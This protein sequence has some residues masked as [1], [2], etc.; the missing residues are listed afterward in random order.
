MAAMAYLPKGMIGAPYLKNNAL[1]EKVIVL[2]IDGMD[3][4]LLRRFVAEGHLPGFKKLIDQGYFSRLATTMPPQSPVAWSSFISGANPGKHGIFDFIHRDPAAFLPYLSTSKTTGSGDTLEIGK[5]NI[6]IESAKVEL[7]R[8]GPVFW[9]VLED[10]GVSS[11]L[12]KIPAAFPIVEKGD[13]TKIMSGMGTP[14]VLGSYGTFN[15]FSEVDVPGSKG[16]T[17]GK[18]F[19]LNPV[20]HVAKATLPGPRNDLVDDVK[21]SEIDFTINRDPWEKT[22]RIDLQDQQLVLKQ[23]EWSEWVPLK[24]E[25]LPMFVSVSGMVRIYVQEVHPYLKIYMTP[26]NVDPANPAIPICNPD[27]YSKD[28]TEAI[29][30]FYTQGF[31]EDT[32]ALSN[33]IFTDEEFWEQAKL[34]L[35]E[36]LKSFHHQFDSFKDGF[37]FY[38]FSSIDQC[39]HML[40]RN[41][42]PGHPLYDPKAS[43][44]VKKA[45]LYLYKKMDKVLQTTLAK[46]DNKTRLMIMS[47]HGFA[48]F[49]REFNVSTWLVE[50]GFT[51]MRNPDKM[52]QCKLY[53]MVDWANTKAYAMGLNGIY[54]NLQDR[55]KQGSLSP[56]EAAEVKRQIITKLNQVKDPVTGKRVIAQ[57][58]DSAEIYDGPFL[59][60]A[61][62]I[63]IGYAEGYRISDE[64]ALGTFPGEV[65]RDRTNKW[66]ADHCMDSAIVPGI[67]LSNTEV[68]K[69]DPALWDLAPTILDAFGLEVPKEMDGKPIFKA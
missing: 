61:P 26:V 2:G 52:E 31:P 53:N 69:K 40:W 24:F 63:I 49:E 37:F 68:K 43:E 64:A 50:N 27:S 46:V 48:T 19:K 11:S 45:L 62:D 32:K 33:G 20:D 29:G 5:Y 3:P 1:A 13:T 10:H 44:K 4:N 65:V 38:Y 67:I 9:N 15:Y 12:Y 21:N 42:H 7:M 47:D 39:T 25:L 28:L 6:P 59:K 51:A 60:L 16:F 41:M 35:D 17:G 56:Y 58:Y 57:A 36:R 23:G 18:V 22:V 66:S 8:K 55:E 34:V 30:R 14:D 54:L